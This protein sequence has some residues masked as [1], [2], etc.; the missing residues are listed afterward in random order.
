MRLAI[1][2]RVTVDGF[3]YEIGSIERTAEGDLGVKCKLV[4]G[5]E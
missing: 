5:C 2:S 1:G 4:K 3:E